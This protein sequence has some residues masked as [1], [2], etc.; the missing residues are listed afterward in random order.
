MSTERAQLV[1]RGIPVEVV[2]KPIRNLHLAVYP[3][4]GHVRVAVPSHIGDETVRMAVV[5]RLNWIRKQQVRFAQ[6]ER[7]SQREMTTGEAQYFRGRRYRLVVVERKGPAEVKLRNNRVMELIVPYGSSD[8]KRRAVLDQWYRE[9]LRARV[10]GLVEKWE[11]I[12]GVRI[13]DWRIRR[14]KT[15]WGSCNA[16]ARRIWLNTELAKKPGVCLEFIVLHEMV[17]VWE[18]KHNERFQAYMDRLMPAWR[19]HRDELN[20]SPL[21]HESWRY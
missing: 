1:V 15:R 8:E 13:A 4:R 10:P 16:G 2:R 14:M 20:R 19:Q 6:Q 7:Q 11:R 5:S 21:G 18:R 17:H 12:A 3:P 9:H